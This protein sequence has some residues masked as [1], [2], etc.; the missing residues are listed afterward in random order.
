MV[1][2][3]NIDPFKYNMELLSEELEINEHFINF[4]QIA[5][6]LPYN[7]SEILFKLET[8]LSKVTHVMKLLD[9]QNE[10]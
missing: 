8:R 6:V 10:G 1:R 2:D 5:D 4:L 7:I 9:P 3:A